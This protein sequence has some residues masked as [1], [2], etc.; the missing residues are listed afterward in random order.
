MRIVSL[1]TFFSLK[2]GQI[3]IIL[4]VDCALYI[5]A[6]KEC[7]KPCDYV[8]ICKCSKLH[9]QKMPVKFHDLNID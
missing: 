3:E 4:A 9:Y 6:L 2:A 1:T 5:H 7:L 8:A